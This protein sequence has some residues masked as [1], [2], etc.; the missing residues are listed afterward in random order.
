MDEQTTTTGSCENSEAREVFDPRPP[1]ARAAEAFGLAQQKTRTPDEQRKLDAWHIQT[2][3][4]V[5]G[6]LGAR[7]RPQPPERPLSFPANDDALRQAMA[8]ANKAPRP[9]PDERQLLS[10][11]GSWRLMRWKCEHEGSARVTECF[12]ALRSITAVLVR[13]PGDS[14]LEQAREALVDFL[15]DEWGIV[16][17]SPLPNY[18]GVRELADASARLL[19]PRAE[20]MGAA[21]RDSDREG[22]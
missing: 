7:R 5:V 16:V 20:A 17:P 15:H 9:S 4:A 8:R 10:D 18:F 21:S 3:L 22:W 11:H 19:S 14:V 2:A 1:W 6:D 12:E 13:H